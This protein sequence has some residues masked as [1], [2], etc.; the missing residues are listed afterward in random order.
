MDTKYTV[1]T[2]EITTVPIPMGWSGPEGSLILVRRTYNLK[3][4]NLIAVE[5]YIYSP[6]N[7]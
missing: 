4:I 1:D 7:L 6:L 3:L 2:L 5:L